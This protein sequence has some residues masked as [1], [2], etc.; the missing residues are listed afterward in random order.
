M[1]LKEGT[2]ETLIESESCPPVAEAVFHQML[3]ALDCLALHT[4][5]HRDVKPENILYVTKPDGQYQFQLGDFGLCNHAISA[6]TAVGTPLYLA[7]EIDQNRKQTHKADVWSLFV[8]ML[9]TLNIANFRQKQFKNKRDVREMVLSAALNDG[10]ISNIREMAILDPE[11]R[12]S[13]AQMLVKCFDGVGLSTS[14]T[15]LQAPSTKI[16]SVVA[17][18][19]APASPVSK[20]R[21]TKQKLKSMRKDMDSFVAVAPYRVEKARNPLQTRPSKR[22]SHPIT[23]R[24]P[25]QAL[26]PLSAEKHHVP[27]AFPSTKINAIAKKRYLN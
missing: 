4:V 14:R 17:K 25:E 26:S 8:T 10:V 27:G 16:T 22:S 15:H 20:S 5:I 13:A 7:P 1:G 24:L 3:Q 6:D 9:W 23:E 12:A 2:L 11:K 19:P 21:T 18:I